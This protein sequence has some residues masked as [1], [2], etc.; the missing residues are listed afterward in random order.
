M[1]TPSAWLRHIK[2]NKKTTSL[3]FIAKAKCNRVNDF[4]IT[5]SENHFK[6]GIESNSSISFD[7]QCGGEEEGLENILYHGIVIPALELYNAY[8]VS[9][10]IIE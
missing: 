4:G 8:A 6:C 9:T 3:Q 2:Q 5:L 7:L 10:A 1:M